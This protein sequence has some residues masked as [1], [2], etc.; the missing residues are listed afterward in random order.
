MIT[1]LSPAASAIDEKAPLITGLDGRPKETLD[2]PI[3]VLPPSS[4]RIRR[5]VSSVTRAARS[6][7]LIVMQRQSK[8]I[9]FCP[10]PYFA[11]SSR[12][13][14]ATA[15]RPSLVSGIP[16]SSRRSATTTP[17]YFFTSGK[18]ASILSFFP[19]TE[20]TSGFPL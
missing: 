6:S 15:S 8:R 9:S 2:R 12:I 10:I 19:F 20:L 7:E 16:S 11:A 1:A 5:M 13:F 17:P 3:T 14:R 4:A 18:M